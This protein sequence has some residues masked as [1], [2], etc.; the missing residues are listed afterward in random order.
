[1]SRSKKSSSR[2]T[3][4]K[5]NKSY[6]P[7]LVP[8]T[9]TCFSYLPTEIKDEIW[10]W[11]LPERTNVGGA[12]FFRVH[13]DESI[14]PP[15]WATDQQAPGSWNTS[16][17]P[18][19]YLAKTGLHY[20]SNELRNLWNACLGSRRAFHCRWRKD[21]KVQAGLGWPS[22]ELS[23]GHDQEWIAAYKED[24][25]LRKDELLVFQVSGHVSFQREGLDVALQFSGDSIQNNIGVEYSPAWISGVTLSSYELGTAA[26]PIRD[27]QGELTLLGVLRDVYSLASLDCGGDIWLLDNTLRP[28]KDLTEAHVA[29][30]R[31]VFL[32]RG[33]RYVEVCPTE[34]GTKW[35]LPNAEARAAS[36]GDSSSLN[37]SLDIASFLQ[38]EANGRIEHHGTVANYRD[39]KMKVRVRVLACL[40]NGKLA[41]QDLD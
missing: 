15:T 21:D 24:P 28:G 35:L 36:N 38:R 1:M 30:K 31:E 25:N 40:P 34:I 16:R 39:G 26:F 13:A 33:M 17:N 19:A 3:K 11:A 20:P 4:K 18:S 8:P 41:R 12:H 6:C 22:Y 23:D 27:T 9:F 14:G 32:A 37:S 5:P 7:K 2:S 29:F 10:D